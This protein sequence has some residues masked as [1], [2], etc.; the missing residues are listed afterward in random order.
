MVGTLEGKCIVFQ[1]LHIFILAKGWSI[2]HAKVG[3]NW[4]FSI[5]LNQLIS[6]EWDWKEISKVET[7]I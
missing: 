5:P 4:N 7:T 3:L 6:S 1:I 2:E